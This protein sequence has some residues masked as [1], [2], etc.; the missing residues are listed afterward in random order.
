MNPVIS[1]AA[2]AVIAT[3]V[4][5]VLK[6]SNGE[7]IVPVS[8]AFAAGAF[9]LISGLLRPV[10]SFINEAGSLTGLSAAVLAP[11]MKCVGIGIVSR[12]AAEICR[13]GGQA[14]MAASVELC[15][16][17]CALYSALPIVSTLLDMLE[18]ML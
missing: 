9:F 10:L 5:L 4:C 15:G 1:V 16:A 7:M 13:D 14:A 12:L 18:G 6:R 3:A 8:A 11:V 17:V 2:A